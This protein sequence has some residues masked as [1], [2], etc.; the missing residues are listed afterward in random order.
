MAATVS[1]G[2]GALNLE[3]F[4]AAIDACV[5]P[6]H[7]IMRKDNPAAIEVARHHWPEDTDVEL[8]RRLDESSHPDA[9][10][11]CWLI[12]FGGKA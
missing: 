1:T 4:R 5:N 10:E 6:T 3:K 12:E 8:R 7:W 9:P 2:S 11:G